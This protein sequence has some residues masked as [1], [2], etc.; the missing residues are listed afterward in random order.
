[1]AL[2]QGRAQGIGVSDG[3][4]GLDF[5]GLADEGIIHRRNVNRELIQQVESGPSLNG[6]I[7]TPQGA[8]VLSISAIPVI[9]GPLKID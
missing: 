6:I 2:I 3:V 1:M 7:G 5:S 4:S 8:E 9:G